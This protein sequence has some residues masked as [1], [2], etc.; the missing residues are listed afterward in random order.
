MPDRSPAPGDPAATAREKLPAPRRHPVLHAVD[1][2]RETLPPLHPGGAPV[3]GAVAAGA[4]AVRALRG[5]GTLGAIL[6][7]GAVAAFF[8]APHRATPQRADV[9][10]APADGTV[11]VIGDAEAPPELIAKGFPAG[12]RPR[13]STFLSVYDV[14]VQR[15]PA[16]GQVLAVEHRPGTF[17]SADLPEASEANSR[18]SLWLRDTAGRDL[19]VVQIAGLVAR[20]IVCDAEPGDEVT[21]GET[22]GLIRFGSRV[23]LLLPPGADIGVHVGQRTVGAETVLAELAGGTGSAAGAGG[24]GGPSGQVP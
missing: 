24:P 5:R 10:V 15:I 16:D 21:A 13:V 12:P 14:H 22:Y 7:T 20:R 23:D 19:A 18:T 9:A 3:I 6:T 4:L 11:S 2:V 17:V 1:L 8:R